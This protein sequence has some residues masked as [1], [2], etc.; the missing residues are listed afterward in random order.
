MTLLT[1]HSDDYICAFCYSTMLNPL[2][3]SKNKSIS[4]PK[5]FIQCWVDEPGL[6][7]KCGDQ[8][9]VDGDCQQETALITSHCEAL[10]QAFLFRHADYWRLF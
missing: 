9:Y 10:L 4:L 1:H 8:V 7:R 3:S 6:A 2:F 5:R